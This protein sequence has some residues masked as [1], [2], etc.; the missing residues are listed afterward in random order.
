MICDAG[1]RAYG[2]LGEVHP[3]VAEAWGLTGR[4]VDAAIAI[5][6]LLDLVP[7]E[8]RA[9][10]LPAAQPVD[11]DLSVVVDDGVAVGEVLRITRMTA[12]PLLAEL[13]LF[14]AYRGEQVG[15]G[16]VSYALRLRF[17]PSDATSDERAVDKALNRVRG[18]LQHHLGAEI[19]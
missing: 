13:A 10:G 8:L 7:V 19:R 17:Q 16:R 18:A 14:D 9:A 1:G 12:G 11:R 2:S 6:A 3:E 4:P 5:D 15:A